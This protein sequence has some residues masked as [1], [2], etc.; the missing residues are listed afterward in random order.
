MD[1]EVAAADESGEAI[2]ALFDWLRHEDELRGRVRMR[3]AAPRE[4]EMGS[5]WDALTVAVSG[6]GA[7]T[8]LL[9]SIGTWLRTRRSD[10]KLDLAIGK[11]SLS[12]D[13][14]R[15][16]AD[17]ESLRLLIEAAVKAMHEEDQDAAG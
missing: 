2:T 11:N 4:D 17:P 15:I 13:S 7:L 16:K 12:L 8:V 1:V 3:Q 5:P 14:K 9:A 10:V 6:G